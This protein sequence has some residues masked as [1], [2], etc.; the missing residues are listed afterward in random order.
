M[1]EE[2]LYNWM[3]LAYLEFKM[4]RYENSMVLCEKVLSMDCS[5]ERAFELK[6]DLCKY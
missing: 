2:N 5:H 4:N 6:G 1:D 3:E